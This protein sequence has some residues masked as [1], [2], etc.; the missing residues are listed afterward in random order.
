[1][2]LEIHM[3][4]HKDSRA[5]RHEMMNFGKASWVLKQ[6]TILLSMPFQPAF[7][8]AKGIPSLLFFLENVRLYERRVL[9]FDMQGS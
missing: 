6:S 7:R 8:I 3:A 2:C 5:P 1:M 4:D 9:F